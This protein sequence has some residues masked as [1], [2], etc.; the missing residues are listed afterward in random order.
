MIGSVS[1]NGTVASLNDDGVW[2]SEDLQLADLLNLSFSP[3][4]S[5]PADGPFGHLE[6]NQAAEFLEGEAELESEDPGDP[7]VVY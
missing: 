5:S 2:E 4:E 6:I 1:A 3:S 7:D